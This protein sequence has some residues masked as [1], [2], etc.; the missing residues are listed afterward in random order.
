MTL[1]FQD[2]FNLHEVDLLPPTQTYNLVERAEQLECM[3]RDFALLGGPAQIGHNAGKEV[4]GLDILENVGCLVGD[5]QDVEFFQRLV[6]IAD[7]ER[8]DRSMLSVGGDKLGERGQ[9]RFYA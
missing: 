1:H 5:E 6:D 2:A 7:V 9:K 8:F 4:Q 3:L